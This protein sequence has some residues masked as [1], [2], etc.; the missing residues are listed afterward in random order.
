[1]LSS[2]S[3]GDHPRLSV[4]QLT[5]TNFPYWFTTLTNIATIHECDEFLDSVP[6]PLTDATSVVH[7]TL[8]RDSCPY[9]A[10]IARSVT[11]CTMGTRGLPGLTAGPLQWTRVAPPY[12][13]GPL[14][15]YLV[16]SGLHPFYSSYFNLHYNLAS[17]LRRRGT[18]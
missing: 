8:Y 14:G 11:T 1:M 13:A 5:F 7:C 16:P 6:E 12:H 9:P 2:N 4:V 3:A 15:P 17:P 10:K 18:I